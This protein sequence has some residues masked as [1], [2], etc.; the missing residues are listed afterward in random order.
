MNINSANISRTFARGGVQ[1][2]NTRY[3][4]NVYGT[5]SVTGMIPRALGINSRFPL[6]ATF[7]AGSFRNGNQ[8]L[9]ANRSMASNINFWRNG[10]NLNAGTFP[11]YYNRVDPR[12]YYN[13]VVYPNGYPGF[14]VPRPEF[15]VYGNGT[16]YRYQ[17]QCGRSIP[18]SY[19]PYTYALP[20]TSPSCAPYI[21]AAAIEDP[22]LCR[23]AVIRAGGHP[24]CARE[25]CGV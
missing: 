15:L 23:D 9:L 24:G 22:V 2:N 20:A 16:P 6:N 8:T 14:P 10:Q 11:E 19:N 13:P 1:A 5:R 18:F 4:P 21:G 25:I 3:D 17:S 7:E 12:L